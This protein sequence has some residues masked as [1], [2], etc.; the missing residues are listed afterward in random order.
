MD[1]RK[2][3]FIEKGVNIP[4]DRSLFLLEKEVKEIKGL[5]TRGSDFALD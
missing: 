3:F 5:F 4:F 1:L 2:V